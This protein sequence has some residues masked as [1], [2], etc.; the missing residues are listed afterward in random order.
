M[1]IF[2]RRII[3]PCQQLMSKSSKQ[4]VIKGSKSPPSIKSI[5]PRPLS[6]RQ[7][8]ASQ[9]SA[10]STSSTSSQPRTTP[11]KSP[12]QPLDTRPAFV[13]CVHP[14]PDCLCVRRSRSLD[15]SKQTTQS[16]SSSHT[17]P[18][19][20]RLSHERSSN[21]TRKIRKENSEKALKL[22][23][24]SSTVSLNSSKPISKSQS[25]ISRYVKTFSVN[26]VLTLNNH[27]LCL[28]IVLLASIITEFGRRLWMKQLSVFI[29]SKLE[30]SDI[31]TKYK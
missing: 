25:W 4:E 16:R 14:N 20:R 15:K 8:R 23:M 13:I 6:R 28:C 3:K 22:P 17:R 30:V 21:S 5:S 19:P 26:A 18:S 10:T 24:F 1:D 31:H 12:R 27:L 9:L 2:N 7:S 29:N 11:R